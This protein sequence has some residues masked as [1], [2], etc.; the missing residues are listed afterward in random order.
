MSNNI[1]NMNDYKY[2]WKEELCVDT[3][4][5]SCHVYTN[6][7]TGQIEVVQMNDDGKSNRTIFSIL[8]TEIL[9]DILNRIGAKKVAK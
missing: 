1:V 4:Y 6:S 7:K 3:D 9:R 8:E 5:S 2:P